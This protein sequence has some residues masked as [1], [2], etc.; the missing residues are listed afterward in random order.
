MNRNWELGFKWR[1]TSANPYTPYDVFNSVRVISWDT[2]GQGVL[3]YDL[4]N[5]ERN[6][7]FHQLD[8]R[9]DKKY[10]FKNWTLNIYLDLENV[11]NKVAYLSDY[12]TVERDDSGQPIE[13]PDAPGYYIPKYID[14]TQGQFLPSIGLIVEF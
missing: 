7:P 12:L 14:N 13:D 8:I 3:D 10:Y 6:K 2:Y 9:V 11:Y 4:L 5:T 1:Y